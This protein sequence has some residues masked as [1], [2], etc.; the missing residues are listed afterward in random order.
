VKVEKRIEEL[1]HTLP[2]VA[3]PVAAYVPGLVSGT[4]LFVSGQ[5]PVREGN[6]TCSGKVGRDVT[7]EEAYRA[8]QICCLNGLAVARSLIGDLDRVRRVVRV[9][10]Y[11]NSEGDFASQPQVVNGASELLKDIFGAKGEHARAAV[12]A[13]SLPLN[14][15]VEIEMILEVDG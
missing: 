4:Y 10:G 15:A 6:L 3:A 9:A 2:E 12:G 1:G 7:V 8:A 11:V 13:S 14:A 5:L